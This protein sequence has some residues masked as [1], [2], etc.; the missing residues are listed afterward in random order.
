MLPPCRVCGEKAS[1]LHY[2]VN[3]CE[4]CKAFF[5]RNLQRGAGYKCLENNK[6][7][8]LP[9]KR[10]SCSA[11]RFNKCLALGMCKEGLCVFC[12]Y[13]YYYYYYLFLLVIIIANLCSTTDSN[14]RNVLL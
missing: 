1:G 7:L 12:Y 4:A 11:C 5:R 6:C 8:I 9:G 14:Y 2:G 3:T 10:S 13:Y